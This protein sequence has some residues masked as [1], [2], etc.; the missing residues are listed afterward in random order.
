M[1]TWYNKYR[2][3]SFKTFYGNEALIEAVQNQLTGDIPHTWL[4]TGATNNGKT[5]LARLIARKLLGVSL[6]EDILQHR[7]YHEINVGTDKSI[8][9]MRAVADN[10]TY[11]PREGDYKVIHL[12]ECHKLVDNSASVLL[13]PLEEPP[14][15][16]VVLLS[17]NEPEKM[18]ETIRNRAYRVRLEPMNAEAMEKLLERVAEKEEIKFLSPEI[19]SKFALNFEGQPRQALTVLQALNNSHK[20]KLTKED[21]KR[22]IVAALETDNQ[23]ALNI[24]KALYTGDYNNACKLSQEV[25]DVG[26]IVRILQE[27]NHWLICRA[28]GAP[29]LSYGIYKML[30]SE[31]K[32]IKGELSLPKMLKVQSTL[33]ELK[34]KM[35]YTNVNVPKHEFL[36]ELAN[37]LFFIKDMK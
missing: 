11:R 3:K 27:M 17:T 4:I 24:L 36:C 31:I 21:F 29:C 13:K 26:Y 22:E 18:L 33:L 28:T 7:D 5:T 9:K 37:L 23:Y 32:A 16:V 34:R 12:D 15:H 1:S 2:P 6:K 14:K 10:M 35:I 30:W 8:D 20:T 19:L 25:K